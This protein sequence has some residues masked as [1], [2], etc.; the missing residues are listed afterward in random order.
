V[1]RK[2]SGAA[3][4]S[5]ASL[6]GHSGSA[7][8]VA[9]LVRECEGLRQRV[10]ELEA[11]LDAIRSG[12]VDALVVPGRH[13]PQV[14]TREGAESAY[15]S[16]VQEMGDGALTIAADGHAVLYC[17]QRF[18][19]LL[20]TTAARV[21]GGSVLDWTDPDR[22]RVLER[23]L[24]IAR[25][26]RT[27]V[28]TELRAADGSARP[29]RVAIAPFRLDDGQGGLCLTVAEMEPSRAVGTRR[30]ARMRERLEHEHQLAHTDSLT[31]LLNRRGFGRALAREARR[32]ARYHRPFTLAY[33]D[34]DNFKQINDTWG[35]SAGDEALRR[36]AAVLAESTRDIDVITRLGGDEFAM[37][38]PE[39]DPEAART[40]MTRLRQRL[41]RVGTDDSWTVTFSV[42]ALT[43]LEP[44]PSVEDL[45]AQADGLMYTAKTMGKNTVVYG[46][47]AWPTG[48]GVRTPRRVG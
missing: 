33:L 19:E 2:R 3:P 28:E 27:S 6:D 29:V 46:T 22:R 34:V 9:E 21:I 7:S 25:G 44:P 40:A 12:G 20:R 38:L 17:N 16:F 1:T 15:R 14:F 32:L 41:L 48:L 45:M 8:R 4:R 11:T 5:L 35:H 18:A 39:T 31:G 43:C 23:G 30:L 47:G 24:R 36:V 26:K 13:G 42:G 10:A 37:L